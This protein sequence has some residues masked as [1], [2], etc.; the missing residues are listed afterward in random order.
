EGCFEIALPTSELDYPTTSIIAIREDFLGAELQVHYLQSQADRTGKVPLPDMRLFPAGTVVIDP[1][2]PEQNEGSMEQVRFL[3][4]TAADD[5][6]PW[7]EDLWATAG[8]DSCSVFRT[9]DLPINRLQSVYVPADV[10]LTLTIGRHLEEFAPVVIENVRLGQNEVLDLGRVEFPP[11]IQVVAR[12]I[13]SAGKPLEGI[14]IR[15]LPDGLDTANRCGVTDVEGCAH[16]YVPPHSQ[17][18]L[19]AEYDNDQTGNTVREG[20]AY[21]VAGDED[22]GKEFILPL[23][24]EFLKGLLE[25]R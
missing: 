20:I 22:A 2:V 12:V 19:V 4:A 6:T 5:P 14:A 21:L 9:F 8:D 10:T 7:L 23:S 3:Y 18:Q 11:A 25:S 16:V 24:D 17:G 13:D 1:C 15:C